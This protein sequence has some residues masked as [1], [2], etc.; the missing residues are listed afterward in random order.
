[1]PVHARVGTLIYHFFQG[2]VGVQTSKSL[3]FSSP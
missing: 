2:N 1:M 3:P